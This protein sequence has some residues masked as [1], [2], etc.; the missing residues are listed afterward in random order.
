MSKK[1]TKTHV[2]NE[3]LKQLNAPVSSDIVVYIQGDRKAIFFHHW[4]D[5]YH[6]FHFRDKRTKPIKCRKTDFLAT[7]THDGD[8]L[9]GDILHVFTKGEQ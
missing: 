6:A 9:P 3:M 1:K 8:L 5:R 7:L 4:K 2:T